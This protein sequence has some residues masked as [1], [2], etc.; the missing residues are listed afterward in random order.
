MHFIPLAWLQGH[1]VVLVGYRGVASRLYNKAVT[2]DYDPRRDYARELNQDDTVLGSP[3]ALLLRG[4]MAGN[5]PSEPL[6]DQLRTVQPTD[7]EV[8]FLNGSIDFSTPAQ[9]TEERLVPAYSRAIHLVVSEM[10]HADML[11]LQPAASDQ[12]LSRFFVP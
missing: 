10:G 4:A 11:H 12:L 5:W 1:D 2:A 9:N 7:A 8:L 3:L 6:S